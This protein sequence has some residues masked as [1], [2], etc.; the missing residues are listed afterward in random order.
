VPHKKAQQIQ[1]IGHKCPVKVKGKAGE[2]SVGNFRQFEE[3]ARRSIRYNVLFYLVE[4]V[5]LLSRTRRMVKGE[6]E[7]RDCRR[8]LGIDQVN[9]TYS[10][11]L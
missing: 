4:Q 7:S 2:N 5:V 9:R 10:C 11:Y 3:T 1:A 8:A 6:G